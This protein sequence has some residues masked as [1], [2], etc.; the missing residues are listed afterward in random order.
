MYVGDRGV[1]G[2]SRLVD[3]LLYVAVAEVRAGSVQQL[4]LSLDPAGSVELLDDGRPIPPELLPDLLTRVGTGGMFSVPDPAGPYSSLRLETASVF[5][6]SKQ[7]E[8][9]AWEESR[10]WQLRGEAGFLCASPVPEPFQE[11]RLASPR[12]TRIKF[13]PDLPLFEPNLTLDPVRLHLRCRELACLFPGLRV[14]FRSARLEE[15]IHYARGLA[16][17]VDEMTMYTLPQLPTPIVVEER[18]EDIRVRCALQWT[19][20]SD[21]Q[22]RSFVNTF[23]TRRGGTHVK[24]TLDAL[25]TAMATVRRH[26]KPLPAERLLPGLCLIVAVDGPPA[27]LQY[28]N[29][30]GERLVADELRKGVAAVLTPVLTQA[31]RERKDLGVF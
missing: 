8:L 26:K 30:L 25:G 15:Q 14:H 3:F 1:L 17:L 19:E 13:T 2:L 28:S 10:R 31:I 23:C 4:R 20:R 18:W 5:A 12:G 6:L 27:L 16:D 21:C 9:E 7:F 29:F 22:V 24:G 11:T